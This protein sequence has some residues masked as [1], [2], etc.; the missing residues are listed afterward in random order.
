M[1]LSLTAFILSSCTHDPVIP[2]D[3]AIS[4]NE[5]VLP[6]IVSNCASEGC[7]DG[8]ASGEEDLDPLQNYD[9]IKGI[10]K[11]GDARGSRLYRNITAIGGEDAMPPGRSL[12]EEQIRL[13]YI[14]IMQGAKN[15]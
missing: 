5:Q 11:P 10:V 7:H 2:Q 13:I 12:S 4:F 15:N 14:W 9:Q 6:I 8:K 3:P 1:A